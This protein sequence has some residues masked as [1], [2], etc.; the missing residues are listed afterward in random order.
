MRY[1]I[2]LVVAIFNINSTLLAEECKGIM[3]ATGDFSV[4]TCNNKYGV[5]DRTIHKFLIKPMYDDIKA[6]GDDLFASEHHNY[7]KIIFS[8]K[9]KGKYG[10]I[11]AKGEILNQPEFDNISSIGSQTRYISVKKG[12][13]FGVFDIYEKHLVKPVVYNNVSINLLKEVYVVEGT[14]KKILHPLR[15]S[16]K[17]VGIVLAS[18][19]IVIGALPIW[20]GV[21]NILLHEG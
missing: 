12:N 15:N 1:I 18:P 8:F 7:K 5:V 20:F 2:L 3:R 10:L 4:V 11:D 13:S 9:S 14:N 17:F 21:G 19:I 16:A 6:F